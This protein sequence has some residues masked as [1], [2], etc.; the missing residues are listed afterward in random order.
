MR[1]I[2]LSIQTLKHLIYRLYIH[3]QQKLSQSESKFDFPFEFVDHSVK[4]RILGLFC[5][6]Y[7]I[8][9]CVSRNAI[10]YLHNGAE[11][12]FDI[13]RRKLIFLSVIEDLYSPQDLTTNPLFLILVISFLNTAHICIPRRPKIFEKSASY[14]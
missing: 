11:T 3:I 2:D 14:F 12:L 6:C 1:K 5:S 8:C 7:H 13:G 4:F 9:R 10:S